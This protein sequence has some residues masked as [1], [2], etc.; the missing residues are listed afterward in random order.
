MVEQGLQPPI[1]CVSVG[2]NG[3]MIGCHYI[4]NDGSGLD[5]RV[6]AEYIQDPGMVCPINIYFSDSSGRA[7]KVLIESGG[8]VAVN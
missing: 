4:E 2:A 8:G 5:C 7:E 3:S 1:Y 6:V